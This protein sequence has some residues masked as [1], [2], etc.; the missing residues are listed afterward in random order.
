MKRISAIVCKMWESKW[1]TVVKYTLPLFLI[2][3][4]YTKKESESYLFIQL[5]ELGLVIVISDIIRNKIIRRFVNTLFLLILNVQIAVMIFGTTYVTW[6]M[7]SNLSSLEDLTGHGRVYVFAFL[8]VIIDL[9]LPVNTIFNVLNEN[10]KLKC[11]SGCLVAELVLTM[12]L[13]AEF[14]PIY[15]IFLTASDGV[16]VVSKAKEYA[17]S[18]VDASEFYTDSVIDCISKPNYLPDNPNV[19][20]IFTE[21]LSQNIITDERII[22]PN[23]REYESKSINFTNYY[24]HTFATYKG[25]IGQLYSGYT[26]EDGN[27]NNLT[28]VQDIFKDQGYTTSFI[29]TEPE[30]YQFTRYLESFGFDSLISD[31]NGNQTGVLNSLTDKEAYDTL[32][33]VVSEQAESGEPFFTS[34]YTFGTHCSLDSPDEIYGD[35]S[36]PLLNKFYNMDYQFGKFMEKFEES[37]L[38]DNTIIVFTTDHCTYEDDDFISTFP[39]Y[40]RESYECDIIPF[41]IYYKGMYPFERDAEGCTSIALA[42]T[43]LDFLDLSAPNYFLGSSVFSNVLAKGDFNTV[44]A[45]SINM[46]ETSNG[47]EELSD[48]ESD[49]IGGKLDRYYI[50]SQQE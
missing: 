7:L 13:G 15:S 44:F 9:I 50:L 30:N 37:E 35:G 10:F 18:S 8:M 42:P 41:F 26:W 39:D 27:T 28:S 25:L 1:V 33:D 43:I 49:I 36:N 14:S 22:T 5:L 24:N 17:N 20:L 45:E 48:I 32:W 12:V 23:L 3:L 11:L 16:S 6:V 40:Y 19:I 4:C 2:L 46:Y 29:N 31:A 34:I 47:I 38:A 21:G